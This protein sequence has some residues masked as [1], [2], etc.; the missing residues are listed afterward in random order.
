M[1]RHKRMFWSDKGIYLKKSLTLS[2]YLSSVDIF[3]SKWV[4]SDRLECILE[5]KREKW[6]AVIIYACIYI[7]AFSVNC[8]MSAVVLIKSFCDQKRPI[9]IFHFHL[10]YNFWPTL[11]MENCLII[12]SG[13]INPL[14]RLIRVSMKLIVKLYIIEIAI[15]CELRRLPTLEISRT[16]S[17]HIFISHF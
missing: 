8:Q 6:S 14:Y 9:K 2:S 7:A 12:I 1:H 16:V 10:K 13:T 11:I 3:F 15:V 5:I 4:T 17:I